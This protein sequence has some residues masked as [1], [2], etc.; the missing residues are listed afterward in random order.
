MEFFTRDFMLLLC[1]TVGIAGCFFVMHLT[2][3]KFNRYK[4]D[5]FCLS[6]LRAMASHSCLL[7]LWVGSY[8]GFVSEKDIVFLE[9]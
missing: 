3:W 2:I 6:L 4:A 1:L 7:A 5:H 8:P 9:P